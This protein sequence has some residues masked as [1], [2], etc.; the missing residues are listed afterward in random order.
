MANESVFPAAAPVTIGRGLVA[1][2]FQFYLSGTESLRV[3]TIT[4]FFA[5][6]VD[7]AWR[8]W[9]ED[10][11]AIQ[12]NRQAIRVSG[13]VATDT[14]DIPLDAGAIV[15]LR[16]GTATT[17]PKYGQ[18]FVR[19]EI[20]Q[21]SGPAATVLG[22]LLQGYISAS[23]DLAWP[24][25]PLQSMH[26]SR[27]TVVDAGWDLFQGPLRGEKTVPTGARWVLMAGSLLLTTGAAAG[28]RGAIFEL[29]THAGSYIYRCASDATVGPGSSMQYSIGSGLGLASAPA[30]GI[31]TMACPGQLELFA[32]DIVRM[33]ILNGQVGDVLSGYALQVREW[34]DQ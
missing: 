33:L 32:G 22:T 7:V 12:I 4:R 1:S 17:L 29:F 20:V 10:T 5:V 27:G 19:V 26:D 28:T 23:N 3:T 31:G 8:F 6:D 21:G 15:N 34:L 9:R 14:T 16:V 30:N 25:S 2:S 24:G 18:V 13:L 11:R